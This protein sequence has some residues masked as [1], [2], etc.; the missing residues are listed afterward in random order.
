MSRSVS[1][2]TRSDCDWGGSS[3]SEEDGIPASVDRH[4]RALAD[5]KTDVGGWRFRVL[6][7]LRAVFFVYGSGSGGLVLLY[8]AEGSSAVAVGG[9]VGRRYQVSGLGECFIV[10]VLHFLLDYHLVCLFQ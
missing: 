4:V 6:S 7:S 2:S 10:V 5:R 1:E 8:F 9:R 3:R